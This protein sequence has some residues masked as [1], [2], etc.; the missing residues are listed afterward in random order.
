M[1]TNG[2]RGTLT[3]VIRS[4]D[5]KVDMLVIKLV[6]HKAG[7]ENRKNH[8]SLSKKY[9]GCVFIKRVS[10]QY[11]L[12]KKSYDVG[13]TATVIQFP[14]RLSYAITAHKVQGQSLLHPMTVAMKLN[15]AFEPGQVYIMLSRIQSIDPTLDCWRT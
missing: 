15:S 14:V 9:E 11:S 13:T 2:Q 8:P 3:D 6:N 10:M 1:L 7:E 4:T 5:N 12:R